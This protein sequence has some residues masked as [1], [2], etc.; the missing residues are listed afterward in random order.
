MSHFIFNIGVT[1][2]GPTAF[3]NI[4]ANF[5]CKPRLLPFSAIELKVRIDVFVG[6]TFCTAVS[7]FFMFPE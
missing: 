5:Y 1:E 3:A 7:I 6:T 2:A 4:G